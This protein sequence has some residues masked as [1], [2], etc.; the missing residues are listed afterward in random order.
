MPLLLLIGGHFKTPLLVDLQTQRQLIRFQLLVDAFTSD[1][2]ATVNN[3]VRFALSVR[4]QFCPKRVS[5]QGAGEQMAIHYYYAF[6]CNCYICLRLVILT[7][8]MSSHRVLKVSRQAQVNRVSQ[9]IYIF[10]CHLYS[11]QKSILYVVSLS[12]HDH[13]KCICL[14]F[15]L[16]GHSLKCCV[17][18]MQHNYTPTQR[19]V[20]IEMQA[21]LV[22]LFNIF[23]PNV[24][25]AISCLDQR[26]I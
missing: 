19:N 6:L 24:C 3:S 8:S 2:T 22:Q 1:L 23:A 11:K 20:R 9:I 10:P 26:T 4:S 17:L 12:S 7:I 13:I 16:L 14:C 21:T 15:I 5:V 25:N 18:L